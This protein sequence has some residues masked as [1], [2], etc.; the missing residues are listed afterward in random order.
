MRKLNQTQKEKIV[1]DFGRLGYIIVMNT[2]KYGNEKN[3]IEEDID[4]AYD[5]MLQ[6]AE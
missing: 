2:E 6:Q 5:I 1:K 4:F 3:T